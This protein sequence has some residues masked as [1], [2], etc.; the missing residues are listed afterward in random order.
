MNIIDK[1]EEISAED[2]M[3]KVRNNIKKRRI[4]ENN[5]VVINE[6]DFSYIN[7]NWDLHVDYKISSHRSPIISR[8]LIFG[9]TLVHG[10]VKR[11]VSLIIGKQAEF[12]MHIIRIL[13]G[14]I[15]NIDTKI[16]DIVISLNKDID[17]KIDTKINDI[18]ISLN[19]DIDNKIDTKTN[20][21]VISLNKDID[22]K[23]LDIYKES[24]TEDYLKKNIE[25][26]N[27][28]VSI[29]NRYSPRF[30]KTDIP[31]LVEIGIG[32]ATMSI[33]FSR[34]SY[35]VLGIDK[36]P[37]IVSNAINTN[38][39]LGGHAKFIC[40]DAF[41][42]QKYFKEKLFDIAFSQGT[43][44]HFDNNDLKRIIDAQLYIAKCMIFSV[45]SINYPNSEF[46]NERKMDINKW[47]TLL[48]GFGYNV[49]HISYYY[50]GDLHIVGVVLPS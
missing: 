11:Y 20:D 5:T 21:I 13:S 18:V 3:L 27:N 40:A 12:N 33:Y 29:I 39:K 4:N 14:L 22:S 34:S 32:T 8:L 36:D 17:N 6:K 43:L 19:K 24:I 42:L 35:D 10:E 7:S 46:G 9:R 31:R 47:E 28:F 45:P 50:E 41:E 25:Y 15:K 48:K 38:K 37:I 1:N 30:S 23:W 26:H 49:E 44:E 16:N 2:M